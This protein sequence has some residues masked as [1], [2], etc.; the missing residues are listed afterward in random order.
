MKAVE[1]KVRKK[2]TFTLKEKKEHLLFTSCLCVQNRFS[3][4]LSTWFFTKCSG[5]VGGVG[6]RD[7]KWFV[8]QQKNVSCCFNKCTDLFC[9][10]AHFKTHQRTFQWFSRTRTPTA[11]RA[12]SENGATISSVLE[13]HLKFSHQ[14]VCGAYGGLFA[15]G[16]FVCLFSF[17]V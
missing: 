2:E 17:R 16:L 10:Q 15:R 12:K 3:H 11:E 13:Q 7:S 8:R 4:S 6:W 9:W 5:G 1:E 14:S